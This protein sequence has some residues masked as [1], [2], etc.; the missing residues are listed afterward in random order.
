MTYEYKCD[1]C[2]RFYEVKATVAEKTK[3]LELVC[4]QCESAEATQV[5][6]SVFVLSGSK[7]GGF[8]PPSCGPGAGGTCCS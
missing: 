6:T 4:P 7:P 1:A 5:F 2:G 8:V 3:G